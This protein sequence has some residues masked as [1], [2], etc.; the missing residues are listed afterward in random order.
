[1][2]LVLAEGSLG[3]G[4][5]VDV[6]GVVRARVFPSE[7]VETK[8]RSELSEVL[9]EPSEVDPMGPDASEGDEIPER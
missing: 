5:P 4:L 2:T 9:P 1:M 8:V 6:S 3:M 7:S